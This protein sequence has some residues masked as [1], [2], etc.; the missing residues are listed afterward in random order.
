MAEDV[1]QHRSNLLET[2]LGGFSPTE[3]EEFRRYLRR[4]YENLGTFLDANVRNKDHDERI[5]SPQRLVRRR[6][7][8]RTQ[9]TTGR[10]AHLQRT[11]GDLPPRRRNGGGAFRPLSASQGDALGRPSRRRLDRMRL[12]R[13]SLRRRRNVYAHPLGRDSAGVVPCPRISRR[14]NTRFYLGLDRRSATGRPGA[15][16]RPEPQ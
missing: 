16:S 6:D 4:T 15:D 12:S 5:V 1:L 14:R 13:I 9:R 2:M 8:G 7:D 3:A 11:D 10:A